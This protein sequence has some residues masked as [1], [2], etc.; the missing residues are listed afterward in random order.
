MD[1]EKY[2]KRICRGFILRKFTACIISKRVESRSIVLN[3]A[4]YCYLKKMF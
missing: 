1:E 2:I 4:N 3:V